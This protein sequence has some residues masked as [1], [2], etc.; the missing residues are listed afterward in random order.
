MASAVIGAVFLI[1]YTF[2]YLGIA[3]PFFFILYYLASTFYR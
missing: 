1:F 3:I 2:P